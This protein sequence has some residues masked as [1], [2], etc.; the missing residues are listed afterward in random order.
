MATVLIIS[1]GHS[2]S[3]VRRQPWAYLQGIADQLDTAGHD[4]VVVGDGP[5]E[6]DE[7]LSTGF[8]QVDSVRDPEDIEAAAAEIAPDVCLW[9]VS[10]ST[11]IY[12]FNRLPQVGATM[13]AIVP[14]PL[15]TARDLSSQLTIRDLFRFSSYAAIAIS[16][17]VPE[18]VF[19]SFLRRQFDIFIA[20]TMTILENLEDHGVSMDDTI[21]VPHG[22]DCGILTTPSENDRFREIVPTPPETGYI[23][24]FGPPRPIRG[25]FDFVES[26]L[27][28][29]NRGYDVQGVFLAR[30]D[31]GDDQAKL[32][33]IEQKLADRG[34]QDAILIVD[35]YLQPFE[36]KTY[37]ENAKAS[38]LPYRLVQ[39]TVPISI[40]EA[41][42][43]GSH[44]VTTDVDGARELVPSGF[45]VPT[46][47]PKAIALAIR[48]ILD[49]D[50]NE[51]PSGESSTQHYP[52][53]SEAVSPLLETIKQDH[54]GGNN[55]E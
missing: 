50:T 23:V 55:N 42:G 43:L 5:V 37:I 35:E 21:Y 1:P 24:N 31:D 52:S 15:Y 2:P 34:E 3:R 14:G 8:V 11:S 28:L 26:L 25:V 22:S 38:V 6:E 36:L 13:G 33:R 51:N 53:W 39:S 30:I 20:P 9:S 10:P 54:R 19:S 32:N 47:D 44:V 46:N 27:L 17:L 49:G 7:P 48:P 16:S 18:T 40:L 4:A 45:A 12:L 41:I 29:R